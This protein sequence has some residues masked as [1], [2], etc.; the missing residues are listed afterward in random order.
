MGQRRQV[1][2]EQAARPSAIS[3]ARLPPNHAPPRHLRHHRRHFQP[4]RTGAARARTPER[5]AKLGNRPFRVRDRCDSAF[6]RKAR[7][8]RRDA[9][10]RRPASAGEGTD[11]A[12]AGPEDFH[13]PGACGDPPRRLRADPEFAP[14]RPAER[15]RPPGR[16]RRIHAPR[17]PQRQDRPDPGRSG[18][19]RDRG[20]IGVAGR[21]RPEAARGRNLHAHRGPSRPFVGRA[22]PPRSRP[23]LRG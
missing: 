8:P 9:S 4:A 12:L 15:R 10:D 11:G 19:R 5:P 7:S 17:L 16:A 13:G 1:A 23:G 22:R 2:P 21:F 20:P 6:A 3:S 14:R 18:A